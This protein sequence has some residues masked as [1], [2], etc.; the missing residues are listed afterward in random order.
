MAGECW[1]L[2]ADVP[3]PSRSLRVSRGFRESQQGGRRLSR[4][5]WV[6]SLRDENR[7]RPRDAVR[8]AFGKMERQRCGWLRGQG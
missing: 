3:T 7:Q 6:L 5:S 8:F 2:E 1:G 4:A